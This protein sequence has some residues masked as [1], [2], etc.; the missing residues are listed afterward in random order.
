MKCCSPAA[1]VFL[2]RIHGKMATKENNI[3]A[4][5]CQKGRPLSKQVTPVI[6]THVLSSSFGIITNNDNTITIASIYVCVCVCV[7]VCIYI[8]I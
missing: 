1:T 3:V 4:Q 5:F 8:Y 7:C 2:A 6:Y